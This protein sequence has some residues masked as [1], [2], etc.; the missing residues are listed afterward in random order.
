MQLFKVEV[1]NALT[2]ESYT[3]REMST[4]WAMVEERLIEKKVILHPL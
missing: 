2:A 4:K 3:E 1:K